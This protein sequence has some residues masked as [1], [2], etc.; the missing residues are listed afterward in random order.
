MRISRRTL[1]AGAGAGAL[2]VLLASCTGDDPRPGPTEP[3]EPTASPEPLGEVPAAAAFVR[4]Q[5]AEDPFAHGARSVTP[6]GS[7][8][9]DR[10]AIARPIADRVFLSGEATSA[11]KPGTIAGAIE[12]G[13]AAAAALLE[14]A[15]PGERIAVIGAGLAGSAAARGLVEA[16]RGLDLTV[17]EA[18]EHTGGRMVSHVDEE[19]WPIPPQLGAWIVADDADLAARFAVL[20][21][22]TVP[23]GEQTARTADGEA[24]MP[25]RD[26]LAKAIERAASEPSDL[27]LDEALEGAGADDSDELDALRAAIAALTGADPATASSWFP[28]AL[29]GSDLLAAVSDVAPLTETVLGDT[30]VTF[31]SPVSGVVYDDTGVSLRLA[32]GEALTFDR[33]VVTVPLGVLQADAI[34]FEPPLPLEIRS[35]I[36]ALEMG[37]IETIWLRFD[38]PFWTTEAGLWHLVGPV[39]DVEETP[40]D[41]G[42]ED[43]EDPPPVVRTWV[44]LMPST[45]EPILVGVIG[46]PDAARFAALDDDEALTL[47]STALQAFAA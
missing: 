27:T 44:N 4:T 1:F 46:G 35:A 18:R 45:G 37:Q 30:E 31:S 6:A 21:V 13:E 32:T 24:E 42:E 23:V 20:G 16:D 36:S 25:D 22:G 8:P 3:P 34:E 5:W 10:E 43:G 33:V 7:S 15:E 29:P 14:R 41:E 12:S 2:A 38:E 39:G 47:A 28:V 26:L 11:D 9:V 40:E 17:F 19:E